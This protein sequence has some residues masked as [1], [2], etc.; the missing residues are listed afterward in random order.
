[1]FNHDNLRCSKRKLRYHI[2]SSIKKNA[3]LVLSYM[4][5]IFISFS[6]FF[7]AFCGVCEAFSDFYIRLSSLTDAFLQTLL[8]HFML[9]GTHMVLRINMPWFMDTHRH[10]CAHS[11][12][13]CADMIIKQA[14]QPTR[15]LIPVTPCFFES[16]I[17]V[18]FTAMDPFRLECIITC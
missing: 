8:T 16:R 3:I 5:D 10:T 12:P 9:S 6:P 7:C 17:M 15:L 4:A 2:G 18:S 11:L 14:T 1:M 13:L